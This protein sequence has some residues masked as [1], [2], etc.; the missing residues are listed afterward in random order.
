[1]WNVIENI[2][3]IMGDIWVEAVTEASGIDEGT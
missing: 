3:V 2:H 1:M